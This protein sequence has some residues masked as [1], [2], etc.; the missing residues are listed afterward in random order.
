MSDS[1]QCH[2]LFNC[3]TSTCLQADNLHWLV[4]WRSTFCN[5]R[6]DL[7][8]SR[9][10]AEPRLGNECQVP[11]QD[12]LVILRWNANGIL[13]EVMALKTVLV[14]QQVDVACIQVAELLSKDKT[15]EIPQC[16]SVRRDRPIQWEARGGGL[17]IYVRVTVPFSAIYP[18]AGTS[19]VLEKLP[20]AIALPGLFSSCPIV[21]P[22]L[23]ATSANSLL[24]TPEWVGHHVKVRW[25]PLSVSE[26]RA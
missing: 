18:A 2:F 20:L 21:V 26:A 14:S 11:R 7:L 23:V 5:S 15:R 13:R 22:S 25:H 3:V 1:C 16:R 24:R 10:G 9:P 12:Q 4:N 19:S 17:M 8:P 6:P